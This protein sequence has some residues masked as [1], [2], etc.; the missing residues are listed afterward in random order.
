MSL[1]RPQNTV[2]ASTTEKDASGAPIGGLSNRPARV[3]IIAA[4]TPKDMRRVISPTNE[5]TDR[6]P[7]AR[8]AA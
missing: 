6:N 3:P 8:L 2:V 1:P 5:S 7:P 4:G